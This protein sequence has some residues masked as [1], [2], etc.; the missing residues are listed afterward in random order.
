MLTRNELEAIRKR[1]EPLRAGPWTANKYMEVVDADG[2]P[3]IDT[4]YDYEANFIANARTD[5]PALLDDLAEQ[6]RVIGRLRGA[7]VFA[8]QH[9]DRRCEHPTV[10]RNDMYDMLSAALAVAN[11]LTPAPGSEG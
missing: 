10:T 5:I 6:E 1:C 7:A 2:R 9:F 11:Q 3:F 8:R 4:G